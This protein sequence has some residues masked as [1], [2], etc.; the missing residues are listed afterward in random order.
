MTKAEVSIPRVVGPEVRV[1]FGSIAE[2]YDITNSVLSMGTH[3][4]WRRRLF[5]YVP[6]LAQGIALDVCTGTGDLLM[7][8]RRKIGRVIGVDFCRPMMSAG[9]KRAG[10]DK[11]SFVQGD[12][13]KLSFPDRFFDVLTVAFGVRNL[14]DLGTGLREMGRVLKPGGQLLILE[15]GQPR[16][17]LFGLLYRFYSRHCMPLIGGLLTGNRA[18]YSYLPKTAGVF[19]CGEQFCVFLRAAGFKIVACEELTGGV[20]YL[21]VAQ[22]G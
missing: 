1:M 4:L 6:T 18:A 15:F 12:A 20:A 16:G 10:R 8:L 9:R 19:P 22:L 21:Y 3:Y 13:L 7:L 14:E 5:H 17:K 11:L 2:R